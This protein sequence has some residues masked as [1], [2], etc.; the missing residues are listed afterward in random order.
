MFAFE[1]YRVSLNIH[2]VL[3]YKRKHLKDET[4]VMVWVFKTRGGIHWHQF[5]LV[6]VVIVGTPG[7]KDKLEPSGEEP[8]AIRQLANPDTRSRE[9]PTGESREDLASMWPSSAPG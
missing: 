3:L 6:M 1:L 2:A 8:Y 7:A 9:D 5:G 4:F